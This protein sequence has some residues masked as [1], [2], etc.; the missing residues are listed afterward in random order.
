MKSL[1]PFGAFALPYRVIWRQFATKLC[2]RHLLSGIGMRECWL[3]ISRDSHQERKSS[4]RPIS[5]I[6]KAWRW[7]CDSLTER[8]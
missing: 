6:E 2:R 4:A 1:F 8:S 3:R 5:R 7:T